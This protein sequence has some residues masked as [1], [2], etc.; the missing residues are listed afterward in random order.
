MLRIALLVLLVGYLPGALLFRLPFADRPRRAALPAE[1]RAFWGVILSVI[2]AAI[3]TMTLAALEMYRFERL[4]WTSGGISALIVLAGRARLRFGRQAPLPSWTALPPLALAALAWYFASFVPP[5]E[6]VM[7]GKDPGVYVNEGIQIA[8]RGTL[9]ITDPTVRAV[10]EPYRDILF[11]DHRDPYYYST[12]FMGFFLLEPASGAVT[13]QFP[14]LYPASMA[15]AYGIHGLSGARWVLVWWSV[16]GV[17]AAYLLGARLFGRPAAIAGAGLLA[18]HVVQVWYSRYPNAEMVL[19]PLLLAAALAYV[20]AQTDAM[21]FFRPVAALLLVLGVLAHLTGLFAVAAIAI[22]AFLGRCAGHR[23]PLSFTGPL[24]IGTVVAVAYYATH[25]PAYFAIPTQFVRFLSPIAL[26]SLVAAGAAV[27]VLWRIAGHPAVAPVLRASVPV[28]LVATLWLAAGYAYF[29]RSAGGALSPQDANSLRVF[30]AVYLTPLGLV[31]ALAGLAVAARRAFWAASPLLGLA[32][33]FSLV[34]FYKMRVIPEHFWAA[35][36]FLAVVLPAALLLAGAAAFSDIAVDPAGRSRLRSRFGA[37]S[38]RILN[39]RWARWTRQ[40]AGVLLV[41]ILVRQFVAATLPI[42]RHVEYAGLIPRL[43]QLAARFGDDDLVFVESR[44]ASDTHVL[45]LPLAYIY[46]RNVVVLAATDPD[47]AAFRGLL[48]W[49]HEHYGRVFFVGGG[50]TELLSRTMPVVPVAGERFQ[51]PEYES[52]WDTY[53][54]RVTFKEFDFGV[55]ELPPGSREP[56]VFDL[57]VGESDDLYVR[58]FHAKETFPGGMTFRWTRDVSFVSIVGA[59]EGCR[60]LTIWMNGAGRPPAAPP[61]GVEVFLND[62]RLGAVTAGDSVQ[63]YS[64]VVP[65]DVAAAMA[66]S[67]NAA[68]LRIETRTWNPRALLGGVDD[69][70]LGVMV[71]RV[72]ACTNAGAQE[73]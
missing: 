27:L 60:D 24:V 19:Q 37:V 21:R 32:A 22:V 46:A 23:L 53:P 11:P 55:Y 28:L 43:E 57:N 12:R 73:S 2:L 1:E 72:R 69:R 7:G 29:L 13:G 52:E 10:P 15:V 35:R 49:A 6:Y 64:F 25:L 38:G 58:R 63:P 50:G 47:K 5:A 51:I 59:P 44:M 36:R 16:L 42:L 45:A 54:T 31:L 66:R 40:A 70:D 71:D 3:A 41:A 8:Q 30:T 56:G 39:D 67:Q 26:A 18:V 61:P 9:A 34:F 62:R 33:V 68:Q 14:H 20:R 4:L 48:S 17:V 65:P